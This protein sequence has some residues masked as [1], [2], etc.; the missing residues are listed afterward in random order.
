MINRNWQHAT[1]VTKILSLHIFN[2]DGPMQ[3]WLDIL[4][5]RSEYSLPSFEGFQKP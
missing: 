4:N 3:F 1:S 2:L 5:Q